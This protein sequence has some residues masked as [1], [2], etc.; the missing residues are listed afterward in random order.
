MDHADI[1]VPDPV[2]PLANPHTTIKR[3]GHAKLV[4]HEGKFAADSCRAALVVDA[5]HAR[6]DL[7]FPCPSTE[8][9][10]NATSWRLAGLGPGWWGK[11]TAWGLQADCKLV[12]RSFLGPT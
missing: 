10:A 2:R 11:T 6:L 3:T 12:L 7:M 5:C 4:K 9:L 8:V 1:K